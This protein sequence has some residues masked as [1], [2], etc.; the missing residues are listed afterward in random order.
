MSRQLKL[1]DRK[2]APQVRFVVPTVED[3]ERYTAQ[4][5]RYGYPTFG[6]FGRALFA[7]IATAKPMSGVIRFGHL[8][9]GKT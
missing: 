6:E 5:R 8:Y 1:E 3:L 7:A 9:R 2:S 4:A